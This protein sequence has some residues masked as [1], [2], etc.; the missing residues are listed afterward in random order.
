MCGLAAF[1]CIK[2]KKALPRASDYGNKD[3]D[4]ASPTRR[5]QISTRGAGVAGE[6]QDERSKTSSRRADDQ[7]LGEGNESG[8]R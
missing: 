2:R 1:S 8:R 4:R 7:K 6:D 5:D 3:D